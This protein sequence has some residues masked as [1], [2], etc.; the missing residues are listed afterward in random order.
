MFELLNAILLCC[1]FVR[2]RQHVR[3]RHPLN[4]RCVLLEKIIKITYYY[5]Y[6]CCFCILLYDVQLTRTY[7]AERKLLLLDFVEKPKNAI[8][9]SIVVDVDKRNA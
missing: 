5:H 9:H 2:R 3:V 4:I 7:T 8:R 6:Y 1:T